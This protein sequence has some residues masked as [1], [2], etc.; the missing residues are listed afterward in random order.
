MN[1]SDVFIDDKFRKWYL[2]IINIDDCNKKK[3]NKHIKY[4]IIRDKIRIFKVVVAIKERHNMDF[5][6]D[7]KRIEVLTKEAKDLNLPKFGYYDG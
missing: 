6:D 3:T 4:G 1:F 7:L 2:K 5:S